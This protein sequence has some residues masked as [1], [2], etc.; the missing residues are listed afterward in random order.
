MPH[1]KEQN[2]Y[3]SYKKECE[4][5]NA[6]R[7]EYLAELREHLKNRKLTNTTFGATLWG[8][9][10][11]KPTQ[12]LARKV[13][14]IFTAKKCKYVVEG[15]E[16]IPDEPVLFAF[17]HQGI[18]DGFVWIPYSKRH[19]IIL[20]GG[21]VNKLL[22]AAQI[23]TG[24]VKVIKGDKKNNQG[25]K[26]DVISLLL[27]KHSIAWFPESTWN[28]SPNKIL[29]PL[30]Y[31][32]IDV[33]RIAQVPIVPVAVENTYSI[34]NDKCIINKVH[35]RF[36]EAIS[37]G[38]LDNLSDVLEMYRERISTMLY[39]MVEQKGIY[40]RHGIDVDKEYA[41]FLEMSFKNLK[42]GKLNWVKEKQYI[43]SANEEF[44]SFYNINEYEFDDDYCEKGLSESIKHYRKIMRKNK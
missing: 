25:A 8:P 29:L 32:F 20:H 3:I 7:I 36:G 38:Q 33:A 43:H 30:N 1:K 40:E 24:L 28:L 5:S 17:N 39:E 26:L 12:K 31:G 9:K 13:A 37:I 2:R 34:K 22:I 15:Q 16:N 21:D 42:L 18:L 11:Y 19:T 41:K 44:Y 23:N 35:M 6:E 14:D 10:L 27:N 4:L